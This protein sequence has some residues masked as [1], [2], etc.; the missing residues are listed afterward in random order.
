MQEGL[1]LCTQNLFAT[2]ECLWLGC[3]CGCVSK[4]CS[5][6]GDWLMWSAYCHPHLTMVSM[7][8]SHVTC[9]PPLSYEE[10]MYVYTSDAIG[11]SHSSENKQMPHH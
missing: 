1:D 7:R 8:E 2:V 9:P 3:S 4:V 11:T 6:I 5:G 10:H